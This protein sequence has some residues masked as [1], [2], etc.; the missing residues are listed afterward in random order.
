MGCDPHSQQF[1]V[2]WGMIHILY[3]QGCDDM[4]CWGHRDKLQETAV[5]GGQ[6]SDT[7]NTSMFCGDIT[8]I[9][10][11]HSCFTHRLLC[12]LNLKYL[13]SK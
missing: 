7:S 8:L 11:P 12:R 2:G 3:M 1:I 9:C 5:S 13:L 4:V 10:M 6:S